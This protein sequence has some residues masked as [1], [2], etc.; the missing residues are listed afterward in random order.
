MSLQNL[1]MWCR[2]KENREPTDIQDGIKYAKEALALDYSNV[3]SWTVLGNAFMAAFF[4]S[5]QNEKYVTKALHAY[6]KA[7]SSIYQT[8]GRLRWW[9]REVV[10]IK[11]VTIIFRME[12]LLSWTEAC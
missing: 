9:A 7:V 11:S 10:R 3:K 12:P 4:A 1:S 6:K 2:M 5:Q 8:S